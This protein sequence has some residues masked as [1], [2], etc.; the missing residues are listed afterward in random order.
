MDAESYVLYGRTKRGNVI[1]S[2][3]GV[4]IQL[5]LKS[6]QHKNGFPLAL[7]KDQNKKQST[8]S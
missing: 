6:N 1:V 8:A 2:S 5:L 7:L 3:A 4:L